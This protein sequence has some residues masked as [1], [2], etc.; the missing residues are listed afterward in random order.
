MLARMNAW[1]RNETDNLAL[2]ECL[3]AIIGISDSPVPSSLVRLSEKKEA[4]ETDPPPFYVPGRV[5]VRPVF[6][7]G[8]A[9]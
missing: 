6:A 1:L 5:R 7:A 4:R 9:G 8:A 2:R 3:E